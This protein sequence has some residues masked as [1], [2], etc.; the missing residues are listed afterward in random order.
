MGLVVAVAEKDG[1][2]LGEGVQAV[3]SELAPDPGLLPAADRHVQ[4]ADGGGAV[5]AHGAGLERLGDADRP[6]EIAR[7]HRC[8]DRNQRG[9]GQNFVN[10]RWGQRERGFSSGT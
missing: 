7:V 2:E 6:R 10:L 1:L 8:W 4:G 5:D 3:H 9:G